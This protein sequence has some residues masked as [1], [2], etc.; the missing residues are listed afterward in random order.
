MNKIFL[1]LLAFVPLAIA[2][3]FL[4]ASPVIIFFL[5]A[6][7]IVPLAK[8]IGESTEHL[9]THTSPAFGG[10]LNATFGN[11]TELI[12]A[13]FALHAGLIAVVQASLTGSIIA[14]LL[15]VGGMAMFFG[16]W[17]RDKQTFNRTG[18][19]A[20]SITLLLSV[21]ALVIPAIFLVTAPGVSTAK[22]EDLSIIV[23]IAMIFSYLAS[24][25]FALRTH[26]HLYYEE[27]VHGPHWSIRKS[28]IVLLGATIIVAWMSE[29][30]VG[31]IEPLI[32]TLGWTELFI[33]VIVVA[34]VGN[35]AEH[36]SAITVAL[37]D[38]MDLALQ[39][40]MG[41]AAQIAMFVAPLLVLL[42]LLFKEQMSLVFNMF[43]VVAVVLSIFIAN[44]ATQD[45]ESNWL[46][47][48]QLLVAY[49][50]IAV[51]FFLH[52]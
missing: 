1:G 25:Y 51:A 20:T 43:E 15:L 17:K 37:K 28:V 6:L 50:I 41:S 40:C 48:L 30:L 24:I 21:V 38:R 42:S 5:A 19:L 9:A 18:I 14:N 31:A 23:S 27:E 13:L 49:F 16:G 3:R 39:I 7:A 26:K 52:P 36:A 32:V 44:L 46:E 2:A 10:F 33:G 34:I 22:I 35:A 8:Y 11:A 12:I 45:G 4:H 47:G 29:I